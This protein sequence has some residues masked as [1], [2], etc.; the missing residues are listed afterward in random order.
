MNNQKIAVFDSGIGG[1]TVLEKLQIA[2]P[3]ESFIFVGDNAHSP[4]GEK[5]KAQLWEYST[6]II[7]FFITQGVKLIVLACNTTSCSVLPDLK[8][9]YAL[10]MIGV[11]DATI[12]NYMRHPLPNVCV[13]ATP[14]TIAQA[15]YQNQIPNCLG[16]AT[17]KL[18]PLIESKQPVEMALKDYLDEVME[19]YHGLILGCTHY[20]IIQDE[21]KKLYP[22]IQLY[23]S[24]DAVCEEVVDYLWSHQLQS[25]RKVF[26]DRIYTTGDVTAFY[27]ASKD[28]FDYQKIMV[29][30]L[31]I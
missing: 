31:V 3:N 1:L 29:E 13:I 22:N 7:D 23:S 18:V 2:L 11:V 28:F 16:I 17:P 26:E 21:I 5:T 19:D 20:P 4:Y 30:K 8:R 9:R 25:D 24:S 10:P 6:K 14:M 12:K 15:T 27:E